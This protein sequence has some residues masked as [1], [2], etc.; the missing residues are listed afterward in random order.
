M[1][2][3]HL[4]VALAGWLIGSVPIGFLVCFYRYGV[5]P[6]KIGSGG[7]GETNVRR[8]LETVMPEAKAKKIAFLIQLADQAKGAIPILFA[9]YILHLDTGLWAIIGVAL[10]LGHCY[11]AFLRLKG[12]KGVATTMGIALAINWP[13][14]LLSYA[15][16]YACKKVLAKKTAEATAVA[17]VIAGIVLANGNNFTLHEPALRWAT[18]TFAASPLTWLFVFTML[19]ILFAHRS[20]GERFF[21]EMRGKR[22]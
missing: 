1:E 18:D 19:H 15:V 3:T 20:N 17:S 21:A 16:W 7:I 10:I 11:S 14:A 12:G 5:D 6:T 9:R 22:D 13:V 4:I 8:A 2:L